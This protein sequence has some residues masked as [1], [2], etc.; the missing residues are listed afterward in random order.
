MHYGDDIEGLDIHVDAGKYHMDDKT[1]LKY[2]RYRSD[3]DSHGANMIG[4][5]GLL[6]MVEKPARQTGAGARRN[7]VNGLFERILPKRVDNEYTGHKLAA[8]IFCFIAVV[9]TVRSSI[10]LFAPDGGAGSIAGMDLSVAGADGIVFAFGLWG[11]SQILYAV[12][13]LVVFFRY[14]ALVPFMYLILVAE[15]ALRMLVGFMKPVHFAHTP[16]GGAANWVILPVGLVMLVLSLKAE[17][18]NRA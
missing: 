17:R 9:G 7:I 6:W 1:A 12:I 16:P 13:Q 18:A 5:P 10:H 8:Y 14:R 2:A 11:S 15:A 3:S 4:E